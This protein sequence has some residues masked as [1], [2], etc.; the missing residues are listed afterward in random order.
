MI[1]VPAGR[2]YCSGTDSE[3][4]EIKEGKMKTRIHHAAIKTTDLEWYA[5]FFQQIFGMTVEKTRGEKPCRQIWLY[6]GIQLIEASEP[7]NPQNHPLYDHISLGVDE[8]PEAVAKTAIAHGCR[9]VEGKGAHW[10]ALPN[11]IQI[12]LKPYR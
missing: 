5:V 6:E 10:F 11:G 12:E 2:A 4:N 9:S 3:N 7:E 8:D 1:T